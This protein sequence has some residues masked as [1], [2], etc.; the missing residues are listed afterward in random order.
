MNITQLSIKRPTL[1]V[2]VFA[3]LTFLGLI[4]YFQLNYELFPNFSQPV[5]VV[6]TPYPGASPAEVENTVTKK[7]EDA[8]SSL[9]DIDNI[10]STSYEGTSLVVII[11]KSSADMEKA[12]DNATMKVRNIEYLLP[13][14]ARTPI[15]SNFS[16]SD[17]PIIRLGV[18][19]NMPATELYDL[20]KNK[21]KPMVSTINGVSQVDMLGGEEREVRINIDNEKLKAHHLSILQVTEAI[22]MANM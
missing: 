20:V 3:V 19:A 16:M 22:R 12:T 21:V 1:V 5:L 4:S 18:T 14:D 9:E 17:I 8:I 13:T 10:Q 2:V 7:I 15:I 11:F 6:V